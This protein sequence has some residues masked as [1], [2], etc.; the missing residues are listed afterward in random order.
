M[1]FTL[2]EEHLALRDN[3]RAFLSKEV[4]LDPYL[5]PGANEK[6]VER[7][8]LWG[9]IQKLGW[10]GIVIPEA[11]G[12]LGL[13]YIDLVMIV[14]ET[15]RTL[16]PSALFGTLAGAWAVERCGSEEQ[17]Q[18]LLPQVAAGELSLAL[19]VADPNGDVNGLSHGAVA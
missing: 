7:D 10:A 13:T 3:A 18:A 9:E 5:K 11:Y 14:G 15:G 1:N 17:K 19:A 16:A 6:P 2:S 4:R 8:G 12:G